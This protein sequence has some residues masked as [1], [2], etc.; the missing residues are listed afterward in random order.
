M[1]SWQAFAILESL[2]DRG[3][4]VTEKSAPNHYLE[5]SGKRPDGGGFYFIC[6][7]ENVPDRLA[8]KLLRYSRIHRLGPLGD[9][10]K[11]ANGDHLKTGQRSN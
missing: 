11:P 9:H 7:E 5:V 1:A 4:A 8:Q 3:W 10:S 6:H 2:R